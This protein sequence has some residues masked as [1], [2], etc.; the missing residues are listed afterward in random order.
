MKTIYSVE[1]DQDIAKIINVSLTKSGYQVYTFPDTKSFWD[2]FRKVKPDLILLDLMLPD[3]NGMDVL[4]T[5]R[6]S[7]ENN[8]I[9]IIILSAKRM[10]MDKV[11]GLD[12]GADDY[13]EKPFD[14]LELISRVNARFRLDHEILSYHDISLDLNRHTCTYQGKSIDLTNTEFSILKLLL[15][16]L[17][18]AITRDEIYHKLYTENDMVESRAIDMHIASL[19]KKFNDKESHII[20]TIYGVGY[21]I[22]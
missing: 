11:E 18:K 17:G 14:I 8:D 1:D 2:A 6:N 20:H 16:N 10:T 13:I 5:L 21:I 15:Q 3:G 19:R 9:K 22:G 4:K 12:C 7:V